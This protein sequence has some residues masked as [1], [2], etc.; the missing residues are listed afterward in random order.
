MI[1]E[2][3]AFARVRLALLSRVVLID[4]LNLIYYSLEFVTCLILGHFRPFFWRCA[5]ILGQR[6][7][8]VGGRDGGWEA[9]AGGWE[10]GA[11]GWEAGAGG[12]G[13]SWQQPLKKLSREAPQ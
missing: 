3:P 5:P 11:G 7:E 10:G 9:G 13:G 8:G 1:V 6:I 12:W 2:I 4:V